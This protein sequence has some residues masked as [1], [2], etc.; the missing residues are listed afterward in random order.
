MLCPSCR[1]DLTIAD[2]QGVEVDYC[3]QCRGVWLER[4]ELDKIVE[5]AAALTPGRHY[6]GELESARDW[7]RRYD[8]DDD[9]RY[10]HGRYRGKRRRGWL[11][12]IFDF[13]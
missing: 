10:E 13:D 11:G 7:G 4:G 9:D 3:P 6:A 1:V 8:D 2:R 5:R 12:E